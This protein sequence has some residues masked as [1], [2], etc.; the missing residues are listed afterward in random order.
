[1]ILALPRHPKMTH[2]PCRLLREKASPA[3]RVAGGRPSQGGTETITARGRTP[4]TSRKPRVQRNRPITMLARPSVGSCVSYDPN[5]IFD[6]AA[7][8]W[9]CYHQAAP[10]HLHSASSSTMH[11]MS[12]AMSRVTLARQL[13]RI[14]A[15][16]SHPIAKGEVRMKQPRHG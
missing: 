9:C 1:V 8:R 15:L 4:R 5:N 14:E 11:R 2:S 3:M 16:H 12:L 13:C 10:A 7:Q 6:T